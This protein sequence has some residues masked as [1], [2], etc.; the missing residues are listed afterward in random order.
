MHDQ[1]C[2]PERSRVTAPRAGVYQVSAGIVWNINTTGTRFLGLRANGDND[3]FHAASR[4]PSFVDI[5]EQ[6]VSTLV[7]LLEGDYVE[8]LVSQNSGSAFNLDPGFKRQHLAMHW[9]GPG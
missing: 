4:V 1:G 8:A 3:L 7:F 6:S 2:A 9:V 5:P